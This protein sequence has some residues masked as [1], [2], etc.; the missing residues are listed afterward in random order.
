[1]RQLLQ[2]SVDILKKISH[3]QVVLLIT[4]RSGSDTPLSAK[5][6]KY[7]ANHVKS[8]LE[9]QF[10][11]AAKKVPR[12]DGMC[13]LFFKCLGKMLKIKSVAAIKSFSPT[14]SLLVH[15]QIK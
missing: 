15:A 10:S 6:D 4:E 12:P 14:S 7:A 13:P 3:I 1:M 9:K 11:W 5:N 8:I 2:K